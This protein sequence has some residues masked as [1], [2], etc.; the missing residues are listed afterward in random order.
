MSP[1]QSPDISVACCARLYNSRL[2]SVQE[3]VLS[4]TD[5]RLKLIIGHVKRIRVI[6]RDSHTVLAMAM[7]QVDFDM[8]KAFTTDVGHSVRLGKQVHCLRG[9]IPPE[10]RLH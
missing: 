10:E 2:E 9:F 8:Q 4:Q 3:T 6:S 5:C 1:S 7:P